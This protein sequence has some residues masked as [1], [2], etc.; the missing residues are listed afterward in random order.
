M[1]HK[2]IIIIATILLTFGPSAGA[3][4]FGLSWISHP[5]PDCISQIWFRQTF[6]QE[7][8]PE[9]ID[10]TVASTGYFELFVNERNVSTDVMA[11]LRAPGDNEAIAV[12]YDI[13]RFVRQ[14][15]N[16]LAVWYSPAT[17]HADSLQLAAMC[18]GRYADGRRFA[19]H[20]DGGWLCHKANACINAD[21]GED[22]DATAFDQSWNGDIA[23]MALWLPTTE[24]QGRPDDSAR[25]RKT[26]YR[27]TKTTHLSRQKYF[28]IEGDSVT[29]TF[30]TAFRGLIRVTLRDA[31]RGS[32][33]SVGNIRYTCSGESDEQIIQRFTT[34]DTR[35]LILTGDKSF[36][37]EQVY[38]VEA[39]S[40][41]EY[42]RE[43]RY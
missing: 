37:P 24:H 36:K 14:G 23:D 18:Y 9:Q 43:W 12:T 15:E 22:I 30:E 11:P 39:L 38:K 34:T 33:I 31:K 10:I 29:Y 6:T 21:G 3:Q 5:V 1:L 42:R 17:V 13:T 8:K 20:T 26:N 7:E 41:G 4:Q 25:E 35:K 2:K 16:T 40:L 19:F 27:A 32:R 28:D